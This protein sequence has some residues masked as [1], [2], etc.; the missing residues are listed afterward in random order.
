MSLDEM[1]FFEGKRAAFSLYEALRSAVL[2]QIGAQRIEARKTQISFKNDHLF[3][4]VSFLPVRRAAERPPVF[5]T[6]TFG[7]GYRLDS[8]RVDAAVEARP[9]RWTHHV[10]IG[11]AAQIDAELLGWIAESARD[12]T[13]RVSRSR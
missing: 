10:L 3:A 6:L 11:D 4:A 1:M 5:I 12:V 2:T 13:A 9:G 8:P 7:L